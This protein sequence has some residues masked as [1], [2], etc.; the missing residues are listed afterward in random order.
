[1]IGSRSFN[2]LKGKSYK[3]GRQRYSGGGRKAQY[4]LVDSALWTWFCDH[5]AKNLPVSAKLLRTEANRLGAQEGVA[6]TAKWV[7]KFRRRH[8]I[9]LRKTQRHTQLTKEERTMR[10]NKFMTFLYLQVVAT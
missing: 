4:F 10:L 9:V 7:D 1:M 2:V 8:K 3:R 5:R 6:I